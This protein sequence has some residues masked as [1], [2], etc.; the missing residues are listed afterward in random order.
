VGAL[1][2]K[3]GGRAAE[4]PERVLAAAAQIEPAHAL[5]D[6]EPSCKVR[7]LMST[8]FHTAVSIER[9]RAGRSDVARRAR[10]GLCAALLAGT[11]ACGDNAPAPPREPTVSAL[12]LIGQQI[13]PRR[14]EYAGTT[15]GGLSGIDYDAAAD[16][17]VLISDDRTTTDSASPPRLYTAAL[18]LDAEALRGVAITSVVTLRRP[19][20]S[21]YPKV[22]D[23]GVADPEAVRINPATGNYA[24]VSEGDRALAAAPPRVID[25]FVREVRPDGTAARSYAL[26][27]MLAM[28]SA[29]LG[30]RG[31]AVLEGMAF[32]PG[33]AQ[34]AVIM[35]SAL[36]QDGPL[37]TPQ[38][39]TVSRLTLFDAAAG[40]AVA[41]YAY[42]VERVQ[43][44]PVP[45]GSFTVNGAVELLALTAT[46]FLV[47]E[48][49]F[50]VGVVGNQVSLYE[51]DV[52]A[53]TDILGT[54]ALAGVPYTPV[55]KRLVLDFE[56]LK[57]QLGGIA[58]LEGMTLGPRLATGNASLV[59]VADDNFPTQDSATDRNQVLAF[60]VLP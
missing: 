58:N 22:P 19:D 5:R 8:R 29:E 18:D 55:T 33:G 26:P 2:R 46:R 1:E 40:A 43:A 20:G 39:G 31:N 45:A 21:P 44:A 50:S 41:Q 23:P 15:V 13:L 60:E 35:E 3:W 51:I 11:P 54:S 42:P 28:T 17:Y 49:S 59:V 12:R 10:L 57:G 16:R 48:R 4:G 6:T 56:S 24:W 36:F 25:P 34:L 47:L 14:L 53:A 9:P 32:T 37:A 38:A 7:A 27:S 30:P 52:S